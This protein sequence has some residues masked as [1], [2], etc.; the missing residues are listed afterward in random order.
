VKNTYVV[1]VYVDNREELVDM[2]D[3][4]ATVNGVTYEVSVKRS[5]PVVR[6]ARKA[7]EGERARAQ[8][9]GGGKLSVNEA[10]LQALDQGPASVGALKEALLSAGKSAASLSTGIAA[11]TKSGKIERSGDGE[12]A[13][14]A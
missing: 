7:P 1:K 5:E 2:F 6:A 11:L 12:Y 14:A 9:S 3:K 8:S 10:I 4:L 13:K